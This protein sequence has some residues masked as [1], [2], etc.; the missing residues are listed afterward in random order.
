MKVIFDQETDSLSLIFRDEK[1][2]ES[3]E[4][5]EGLII[6]YDRKGRIISIE[7]LDA[8]ERITDPNGIK[9]ELKGKRAIPAA[10]HS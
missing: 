10:L 4:L 7:V 5:K 6:D 2:A 9:F 3:D 8:S 1:V